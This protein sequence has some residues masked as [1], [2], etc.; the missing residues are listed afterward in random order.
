MSLLSVLVWVVHQHLHVL[1]SNPE[2]PLPFTFV[3]VLVDKISFTDLHPKHDSD[4][5]LSGHAS[6]VGTSSVEVVVWLEQKHHG[7]W[8]KLTRAL[9]LMASR[10]ATNTKALAV[11]QM[12]PATAEEQ[13]IFDGGAARKKRRILSQKQSLFSVEPNP[14]E[15][16]LIHDMFVKTIDMKNMTFN[17]RVL[18]ANSVWMEDGVVSNIIFSHPEDRNAHNTVFGGFLMR[19]ALELSFALAYQFR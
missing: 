14:F 13:K 15:Q 6:W 16:K 7:K 4:I 18:P 11:N 17:Q 19:H 8:R 9:F 2:V 10:N 1:N 3:T 5:R 12:V